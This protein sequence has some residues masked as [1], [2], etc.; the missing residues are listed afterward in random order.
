[1]KRLGR[2]PIHIRNVSQL[3]PVAENERLFMKLQL[4]FNWTREKKKLNQKCIMSM[5]DDFCHS[6]NIST[7]IP[8]HLYH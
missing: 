5:A 4:L 3:I 6:R 7:T 1:M 2:K 8:F